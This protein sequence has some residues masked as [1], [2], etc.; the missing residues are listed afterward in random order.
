[1]DPAEREVVAVGDMHVLPVRL[2]EPVEVERRGDVV[3]RQANRALDESSRRSSMPRRARAAT[4]TRRYVRGP[5]GIIVELAEQ[6]G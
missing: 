1:M 4:G 2:R 5:E 6:I 3:E